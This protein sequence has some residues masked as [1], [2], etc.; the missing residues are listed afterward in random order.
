MEKILAIFNFLTGPGGAVIFGALW[1]LSEAL[2][3]IP[4]IKANGVFQ[5]ISGWIK[6]I[7]DKIKAKNA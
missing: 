2:S 5:M 6:K 4:S 3:L 1:A 7:L